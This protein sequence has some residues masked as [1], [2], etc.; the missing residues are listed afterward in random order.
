LHSV[1]IRLYRWR[2]SAEDSLPAVKS[3]SVSL[4]VTTRDFIASSMFQP[5]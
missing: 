4:T 2:H 3:L 1:D 5:D